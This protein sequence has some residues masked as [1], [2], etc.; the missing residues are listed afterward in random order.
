MAEQLTGVTKIEAFRGTLKDAKQVIG[1]QQLLT[2]AALRD[3][4][5]PSN[6]EDSSLERPFSISPDQTIKALRKID[7][8]G[9]S[10]FV[11]R[12]TRWAD[13]RFADSFT[14]W[15]DPRRT[16]QNSLIIARSYMIGGLH[17]IFFGDGHISSQG[18]V[19]SFTS[20]TDS[21]SVTAS[22]MKDLGDPQMGRD[23][24]D[25]L[26]RVSTLN[27]MQLIGELINNA[28]PIPLNEY[29]G[30]SVARVSPTR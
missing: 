27:R 2:L 10:Y 22:L 1:Q 8:P 12:Y 13:S 23:F 18:I 6:P 7:E 29:N 30:V 20:T 19:F 26:Q 9:S 3:V 4:V 25:A 11:D 21:V 14:R 15:A 28:E 24:A 17:V 16:Q 5:L